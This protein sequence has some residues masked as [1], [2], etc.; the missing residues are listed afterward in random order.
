[1]STYL[2]AMLVSDFTFAEADLP[3]FGGKP[4]RTYAQPHLIARGGGN[5]SA[6]VAAE[7]LQFYDDYFQ[8]PYP[9][10]KMDSAVVPQFAAGAME[11]SWFE[12]H[13]AITRC[14][15]NLA[16]FVTRRE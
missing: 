11:V 4:V 13:K 7:V 10:M 6:Q 12:M 9:L 14:Y 15:F 3:T 16:D 1:M 2:F 5:Y 8:A